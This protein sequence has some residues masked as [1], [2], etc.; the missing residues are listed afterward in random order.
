M[1]SHC[2]YPRSCQ[3]C[4]HDNPIQSYENKIITST[5]LLSWQLSLGGRGIFLFFHF[6][7]FF[8]LFL[9][10][11]DFFARFSKPIFSPNPVLT[12]S[13]A[14]PLAFLVTHISEFWIPNF[15]GENCEATRRILIK[16]QTVLIIKSLWFMF[17]SSFVSASEF[18]TRLIR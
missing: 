12:I 8:S 13:L 3:A 7:F 9:T 17:C 5:T 18:D 16:H 4:W 15:D 10:D 1:A 2:K 6:Y 11:W 14:I